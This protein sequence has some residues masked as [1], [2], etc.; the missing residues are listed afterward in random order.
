MFKFVPRIVCL[1]CVFMT[2]VSCARS[3]DDSLITRNVT[4]SLRNPFDIQVDNFV[5]RQEPAVYVQPMH[6]ADH[7][8]TALF[9]PLRMTQGISNA[10]TFSNALSRQVWQ[11]WLSLNAFQRLE[12]APADVP[13]EPSSALAQARRIGAELVVGGYITHYFDGGTGGTSSLSLS[14]EIYDVRSGVLLWS[15]SQ[16]GMMESRQVH[17]FYLFT[18]TERNPG[19]PAGLIARS[20]AWDMGRLVLKWVDP[21]AASRGKSGGLLSPFKREAF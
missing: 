15:M 8:P 12:F 20:L 21:F 9:V 14:I 16:G 2:A 13:F 17:D 5:R 10:V 19:D 4:G 18:I 3:P 6:K 7:R 11:I 1:L